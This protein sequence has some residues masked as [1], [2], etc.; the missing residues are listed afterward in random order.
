M[1][2]TVSISGM[3]C[4]HCVKRVEN[5]LGELNGVTSVVVNLAEK[6]AIIEV[7]DNTSDELIRE[8]IDDI[9]YTVEA[10]N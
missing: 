9:G 2:K 1:K 4:G 7:S 8:T 6:N 5:A 10:I 3:T